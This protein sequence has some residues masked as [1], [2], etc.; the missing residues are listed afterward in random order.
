MGDVC[1]SSSHPAVGKASCT[2]ALPA[3]LPHRRF[4]CLK[5]PPCPRG[6]PAACPAALR[7][8]RLPV[9]HGAG[10]SAPAHHKLQLSTAAKGFWGWQGDVDLTSLLVHP[11]AAMQVAAGGCMCC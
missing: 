11:P 2:P 3:K 5:A 1:R 9:A 10:S 8:R 4:P 6:T 7:G